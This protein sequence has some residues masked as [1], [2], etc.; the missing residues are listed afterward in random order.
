M[1]FN[2]TFSRYKFYIEKKV[3]IFFQSLAISRLKG[4]LNGPKVVLNSLPKSG[5]HLIETFFFELPNI[6]HYGGRTIMMN[7]HDNSIE[8]GIKKLSKVG[9][10]QFVPAHIQYD[11]VVYKLFKENQFKVIQMIRDPRDVL[12]SHWLYVKN[13]D[14]THKAHAYIS[15][16]KNDF[17]QFKAI[18]VGEEGIIEPFSN[19]ASKFYGW[20]NKSDILVVRFEDLVGSKGGGSDAVQLKVVKSIAQHIGFSSA[21]ED[22]KTL[23]SKI[24]STKSSTFNTG[25]IGKWKKVFNQEHKDLCKAKIQ[26]ILELYGYEKDASW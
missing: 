26:H 2:N 6:S 3:K 1:K 20:L 18:V 4:R 5:T 7:T 19:V 15:G 12:I 25:T 24:F 10:G 17:E 21:A 13:L 8:S 16:I 14:K 9:K 23:T 11:D 22:L